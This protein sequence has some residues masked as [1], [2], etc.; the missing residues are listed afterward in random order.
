MHKDL[1]RFFEG[2]IM[3]LIKTIY[4]KC[5]RTR[6][7]VHARART[8]TTR[9][10]EEAHDE[11]RIILDQKKTRGI[12]HARVSLP[13]F[14]CHAVEV[15]KRKPSIESPAQS[16]EEMKSYIQKLPLWLPLR[17]GRGASFSF[18]FSIRSKQICRT[19]ASFSRKRLACYPVRLRS[20]MHA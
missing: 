15:R 13:S 6:H 18:S 5:D 11:I 2:Y 3:I 20:T 9:G 17:K 10:L 12:V 16:T 19:L 8:P 14:W 7:Q 4:R 1:N